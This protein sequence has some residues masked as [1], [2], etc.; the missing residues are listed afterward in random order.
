M[1]GVRSGVSGDCRE[2]DGAEAAVR[3]MGCQLCPFWSSPEAPP[4]FAS[5]ERRPPC[6]YLPENGALS[7]SLQGLFLLPTMQHPECQPKCLLMSISETG[8]DRAGVGRVG[9][10][11]EKDGLETKILPKVVTESNLTIQ[12]RGFPAVQFHI[13]S[14]TTQFSKFFFCP[15]FGETHGQY[16]EHI[17]VVQSLSRV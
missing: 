5:L 1:K 4:A 16:L 8:Q 7:T 17:V 6:C 14:H 10:R 15:S 13:I 3:Q 12:I 2:T 11:E 9:G